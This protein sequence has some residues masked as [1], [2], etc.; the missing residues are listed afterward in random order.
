MT[1]KILWEYVRH[2]KVKTLSCLLVAIL[3]VLMSLVPAQMIRMVTDGYETMQDNV[4]MGL[5]IAYMTGYVLTGLLNFLKN[6]MLISFSQGAF[7]YT[8]KRMIEHYSRLDYRSLGETD[9]GTFESYFG[10]DMDS[11]CSLFEDGIID[12][13]F[14]LLK[15]IGIFISIFIYSYIFGL[16]LLV[17][18]PFVICM[19]YFMQRRMLKA[20]RSVKSSDAKSNE[21]LYESIGNIGQIKVN[22][23]YDYSKDRYG[24]ILEDNYRA[25]KRSYFYDGIFSPLMQMIR[26]LVIATILLISG[27]NPT[28]LGMTTGM[29]ISS[30]SL[31]SD[32]FSPIENIGM[33]IQTIQ[34]SI[35]SWQRIDLFMMMKESETSNDPINGFKIEFIHCSYAYED[36]IVI[37]DMSLVIEEGERIVLKGESG[38]GKSTMMKLAMG[39]LAPN[40][41]R[42]LVGG[43]DAYLLTDEER[44][45]LFSVVY[46]DMFFNGDS[47][48]EE[49]TLLDE[50]ISKDRVR[51]VLD[52]VGLE[53]IKSL[54]DKLNPSEYSSGELQLLNI[55]RAIISDSPI[56][57]LDEMNS[58]IDSITAGLLMEL[59]NDSFKGKTV[60]SISHYG[61]QMKN[62]K[63]IDL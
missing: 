18:L 12:M 16:V 62:S 34:Q 39:L 50:S 51:K 57:F 37:D 9:L 55:A 53:H 29:L 23:A 14:D 38:K 35:A 52:E 25:N 5:S 3:A 60:F 6:H 20:Q 63:V 58:K 11:L 13:A 10:N 40:K 42:V 19:T 33:E 24:K 36:A 31:V 21:V 47:I 8:R 2:N 61:S 49:L 54:D 41:G 32:L 45:R 7:A 26:C 17:I 27:F 59:M 22:R 56:V 46:Q 44:K 4:L 43:K 1:R 28:F 30:I 48:Y 15:V